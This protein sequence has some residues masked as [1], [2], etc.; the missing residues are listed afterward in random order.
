MPGR[1][2]KTKAPSD[3]I[4]GLGSKINKSNKLDGIIIMAMKGNELN[5]DVSIP[6]G[7]EVRFLEAMR[8]TTHAIIRSSMEHMIGN[9]TQKTKSKPKKK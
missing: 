9:L 2:V 3:F 7:L 6:R 4:K 5:V 1:P 8:Q